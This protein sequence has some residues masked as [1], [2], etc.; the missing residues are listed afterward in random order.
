MHWSPAIGLRPRGR[1]RREDRGRCQ[2]AQVA[3]DAAY[4]NRWPKMSRRW[5]RADGHH[6]AF[7]APA[8]TAR[9]EHRAARRRAARRD[10]DFGHP[11]GRRR[12]TF[13]RP[14]Y[15]GNAIATVESRTPSW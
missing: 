4:A 11:L 14:I 13:T 3:D 12:K 6:D 10:A 8:T 1:C 9:Q 5:W 15:A 7:V 2:G